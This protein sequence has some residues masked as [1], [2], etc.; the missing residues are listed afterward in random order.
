MYRPSSCPVAYHLQLLASCQR[1]QARLLRYATS[2]VYGGHDQFIRKAH[3]QEFN[4]ETQ[5]AM[6]RAAA[7]KYPTCPNGRKIPDSADSVPEGYDRE[8][9]CQT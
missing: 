2:P 7:Q 9:G 3:Q 6:A 8:C 1:Q 4:A 5:L